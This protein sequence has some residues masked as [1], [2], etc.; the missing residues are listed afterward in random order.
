MNRT[1][2]LGNYGE[3]KCIESLPGT[4]R[5]KGTNRCDQTDAEIAVAASTVRLR[6]EMWV[7]ADGS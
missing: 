1:T 5:K 7:M 3:H 6:V 2:T 4:V